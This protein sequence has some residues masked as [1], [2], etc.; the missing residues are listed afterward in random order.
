MQHHAQKYLEFFFRFWNQHNVIKISA[1]EEMLQASPFYHGSFPLYIW[2]VP[3][4]GLLSL[5]MR[6][7]KTMK[8]PVVPTAGVKPDLVA[9]ENN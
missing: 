9:N 1:L 4:L 7:V 2:G 8:V 3:C 6:M 5:N